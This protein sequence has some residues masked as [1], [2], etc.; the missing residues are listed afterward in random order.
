MIK[1]LKIILLFFYVN[2]IC[3]ET[4]YQSMQSFQESNL[5][6][7]HERFPEEIWKEILKFLPL[8]PAYAYIV[9][10]LKSISDEQ[11]KQIA[12]VFDEFITKRSTTL[13]GFF[14]VFNQELINMPIKYRGKIKKEFDEINKEFYH[15]IERSKLEICSISSWY[16]G[17]F[18][19]CLKK[20]QSQK[21]ERNQLLYELKKIILTIDKYILLDK[22]RAKKN[23][24]I[25]IPILCVLS[26][27]LPIIIL[28]PE[29][30]VKTISDI[31]YSDWSHISIPLII[32]TCFVCY[33]NCCLCGFFNMKFSATHKEIKNLKKL[34]KKINMNIENLLDK[35]EI[36]IVIE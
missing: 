26:F 5:V 33:A 31:S 11:I 10:N 29:G 17:Y 14:N 16:Y 32:I 34:R 30:I 21:L 28:Y 6:T 7:F 22:K 15:E 4:E 1:F 2:I 18:I 13:N 27:L 19:N 9:S 36:E 8:S 3:M 25:F 35:E 12:E 24:A 23:L 20:I